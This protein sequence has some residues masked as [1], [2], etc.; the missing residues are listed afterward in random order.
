M[1]IYQTQVIDFWKLQLQILG[2]PLITKGDYY[3]S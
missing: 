3:L 1:I 2:I